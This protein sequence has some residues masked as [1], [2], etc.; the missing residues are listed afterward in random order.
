MRKFLAAASVISLIVGG[1]AWGATKRV[2]GLSTEKQA[3]LYQVGK[4][5]KTWH[6]A[7]TKKSLD[8]MMSI[9]AP[10]ATMTIGGATYTGKKAVREVF[11]KSGPFQPENHWV[12]D[13]PAYKMRANVSGNKA[14]FHFECHYVDVDT[15]KLALAAGTDLDLRKVG[16]SWLIT[17]FAA[18]SATLSP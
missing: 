4:I 1:T 15:G 9:W 16:G 13:T 18:S 12:S 10:N 7:T 14:T 5:E 2:G 3:A 6:R 8:L 11:A 17:N